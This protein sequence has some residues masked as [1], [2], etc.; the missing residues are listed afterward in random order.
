M[1]KLLNNN[2]LKENFIYRYIDKRYT[3]PNVIISIQEKDKESMITISGDLTQKNLKQDISETWNYLVNINA[4]KLVIN[5]R[6]I[7]KVDESGEGFLISI[8]GFCKI[9]QIEYELISNKKIILK[10]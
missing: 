4:K 6:D 3:W 7:Q 8:I 10:L 9:L 5:A 2:I 1:K